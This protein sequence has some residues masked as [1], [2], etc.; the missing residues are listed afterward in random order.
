MIMPYINAYDSG[1]PMDE[2]CI[3]NTLT[4]NRCRFKKMFH[5]KVSGDLLHSRD[6]RDLKTI[7]RTKGNRKHK[8]CAIA[9]NRC[10]LNARHVR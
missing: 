7:E 2:I 9:G 6:S 10:A 3:K 1:L 4:G 8:A 5:S